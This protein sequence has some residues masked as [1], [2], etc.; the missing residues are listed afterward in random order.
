M[1][2][3]PRLDQTNQKTLLSG[4]I[5]CHRYYRAFGDF[6]DA[7][8]HGTHTMGTLLGATET[9][10]TTANNIVQYEGTAPDAKLA[11]IGACVCACVCACGWILVGRMAGS[12]AVGLGWEGDPAVAAAM[13]AHELERRACG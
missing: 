13:P 11:F 9:S 7:N 8:G 1:A 4:R 12:E 2:D 5:L 3:A 6:S 10:N